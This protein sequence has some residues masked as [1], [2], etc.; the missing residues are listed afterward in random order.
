MKNVR[1]ENVSTATACRKFFSLYLFKRRE[2][3]MKDSI[4]RLKNLCEILI[5]MGVTNTPN[6]K[7]IK[8][9][10][11][12]LET[13]IAKEMELLRDRESMSDL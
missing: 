8:K 7:E 2:A 1:M 13:T 12:D 6:E 3:V 10:I 4:V 5:N 11:I 9:M